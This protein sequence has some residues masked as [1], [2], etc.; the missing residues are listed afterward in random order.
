MAEELNDGDRVAYLEARVGELNNT[1]GRL[2]ARI[3]EAVDETQRRYAKYQS[4]C[5]SFDTWSKWAREHAERM[6]D[7]FWTHTSQAHRLYVMSLQEE[8]DRLRREVEF[9]ANGAD[10]FSGAAAAAAGRPQCAVHLDG[11]GGGQ[12]V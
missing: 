9:E 7:D 12:D 6:G 1:I 2:R 8:I 10:T 3:H 4:R 11:Q 5:A